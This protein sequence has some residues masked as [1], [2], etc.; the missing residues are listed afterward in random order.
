VPKPILT[1]PS[2]T[3]PLDTAAQMLGVSKWTVARL[4][5][6]KKL[7]ASKPERHVLV[8]VADIEAMLNETAVQS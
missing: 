4:V 1:T 3:V 5:K 6:H 7:R 8:R 2:L